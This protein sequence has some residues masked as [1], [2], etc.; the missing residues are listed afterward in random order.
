MT[1]AAKD[2]IEGFGKLLQGKFDTRRIG[3][4]GAAGNLDIELEVLYGSVR[5]M[6]S[7]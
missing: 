5:V 3:T 7:E 4:T 6:N 1:A 2:Q